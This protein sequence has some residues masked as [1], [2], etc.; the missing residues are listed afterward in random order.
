MH[1]GQIAVLDV[2]GAVIVFDLATGPVYAFD[3]DSLARDDLAS[4]R[5]W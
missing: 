4:E 5:N 1:A 3:F 2:V